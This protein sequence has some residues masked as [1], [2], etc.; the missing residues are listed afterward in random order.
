MAPTGG[1]T[2]AELV[3]AVEAEGRDVDLA[4]AV[5]RSGW[6][7]VVL[8]T[9]E[10]IFRFPRG[11]RAA[12]ERELALLSLVDGRLPVPTP[13]IEW[14]GA[15]T[16]F[17]AYRKI[18]GSS[19]DPVA[20]AAAPATDRTIMARSFA[21]FLAAMHC[22][23]TAAEIAELGIPAPGRADGP[24]RSDRAIGGPGRSDEAGRS[25][26]L[27][28]CVQSDQVPPPAR[29]FVTTLLTEAAEHPARGLNVLL[30]NDFH[31]GNLVLDAPV[32][33]LAGVWDFSCVELGPA[34]LDLRYLDNESR[35]LLRRTAA[36]YERIS[37]RSAGVS[38]A[39]VANRIEWVCDL[40]ELGH[41]ERITG[42]V[43]QWRA[44]DAESPA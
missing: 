12:Y 41:P 33:R 1:P 19:F 5:R 21:E 22:C 20:Y 6:E 32:G 28:A 2:L 3:A 25:V 4:G 17:A 16:P 43:D 13:R 29:A 44:A 11:A 26:A 7:N 37:G 30:H 27:G 24:G 9:A 31:C 35:D 36:E 15:R 8:S 18:T 42:L 34:T 39:I 10:W 14:A 38:A 40:V 23:L